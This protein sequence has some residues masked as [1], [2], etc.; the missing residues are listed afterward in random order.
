MRRGE[1][2]SIYQTEKKTFN[3]SRP[4]RKGMFIDVNGKIEKNLS[5]NRL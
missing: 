2:N 1:G 3:V 5:R 4:V